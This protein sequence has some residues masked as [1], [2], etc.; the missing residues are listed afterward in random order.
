MQLWKL[1][2]FKIHY[3]KFFYEEYFKLKKFDG[4]CD[5]INQGYKVFCEYSNEMLSG[6]GRHE[7][8]MREYEGI[9][10][11]QEMYARGAEF[12]EE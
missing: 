10:L 4:L 12:V 2:Y 9:L 7:L 11:A 8:T 1:A 5:A 3:P 6:Y